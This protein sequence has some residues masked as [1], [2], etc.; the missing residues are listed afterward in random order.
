MRSNKYFRKMA[1]GIVY[2]MLSAGLQLSFA[3]SIAIIIDKNIKPYETALGGFKQFLQEDNIAVSVKIYDVEGAGWV[4]DGKKIKDSNPDVIVTFGVETTR[5]AK[6]AIS[7]IPIVFSM[8]FNPEKEGL[9][10]SMEVPGR[11]VTGVCLD[12]PAAD[13]FK[14]MKSLFPEF[15]KVGVVY[16]PVNSDN[17]VKKAKKAA[18]SHGFEMITHSVSSSNEIMPAF[19]NLNGNV[20]LIWAIPDT[21]VYSSAVLKRILMFTLKNKIPLLGFSDSFARA[22]ALM[23]MYCDFE[24]IGKQTAEL[25]IKVLNGKNAGSTPVNS[26][27][28]I[29]V[30][31]NINTAKVLGI[32]VSEEVQGMVDEVLSLRPSDA[33]RN[34]CLLALL[35]ETAEDKRNIAG[36]S[37]RF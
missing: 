12:I 9:V 21:T 22:G 8:V 5:M 30:T 18:V 27:R 35:P 4:L 37:L 16:D 33:G 34:G 19:E 28:N 6:E 13:Q 36:V 14:K 2:I 3:K 32:N 17:F 26:P 24:D 7:D 31:L 10:D 15:K 29:K 1:Y 25:S 23:G 20:D 11:N